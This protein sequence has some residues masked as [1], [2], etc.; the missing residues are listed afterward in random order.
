MPQQTGRGNLNPQGFNFK[1]GSNV[2]RT[3]YLWKN[4]HKLLIVFPA[5]DVVTK[6]PISKT[7]R[8]PQ[9]LKDLLSTRSSIAKTRDTTVTKFEAQHKAVF[10]ILLHE[11]EKPLDF[12]IASCAFGFLLKKKHSPCQSF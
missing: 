2:L 12:S 5:I 11:I 3:R 8:F 1:G 9:T 4:A 7:E 6:R 10:W